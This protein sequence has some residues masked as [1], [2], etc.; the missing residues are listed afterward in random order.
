VASYPD[1]GSAYYEQRSTLDEYLALHFPDP[2]P[3]PAVL[4]P[5]APG[6]DARFPYGVHRL[7]EARP[8]GLGL[9]VGAACGR[10]TFDLARDH[11]AAF[12]LDLSHT[13]IRGAEQV[14]RTGRARYRTVDEGALLD[15]FDVAV[16]V[17]PSARFLVGDA[18][19]L[20]FGDG[21][22]VTVVALNLID[23]VP[24]PLLALDELAR[25]VA[26]GG[27]LLVGSPYTWLE[28]FTDRERW[29]G[30]FMRD[31]APVRGRDTI[32]SHLSST[33][34]F[35]SEARMPFYIPHHARSGQL[36]VAHIQKFRRP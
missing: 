35:E 18:L 16:D 17:A 36:G 32:R 12:G 34:T 4:G 22:F 25:M 13:L 7:W 3:L 21:D 15:T 6:M 5:A 2:D 27:A 31:G 23:R 1:D 10:V 28:S 20:P 11:R 19:S 14:R 30:G 33:L 24:D 26:P 8:D 29:L 9:D